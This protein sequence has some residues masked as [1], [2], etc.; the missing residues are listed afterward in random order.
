[1]CLDRGEESKDTIFGFL[2]DKQGLAKRKIWVAYLRDLERDSLAWEFQTT[3]SLTKSTTFIK[4]RHR[5]SMYSNNK[6]MPFHNACGTF[7][8]NVSLAISLQMNIHTHNNTSN[9]HNNNTS[10]T[11]RL[12]AW[13]SSKNGF[14]RRV[15]TLTDGTGRKDGRV[16]ITLR[17]KVI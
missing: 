17:K 10:N 1:M 16:Y 15:W 11:Q 3:I 2:F 14:L 6:V 9:T 8:S 4:M 12:D 13:R 5:R 7:A